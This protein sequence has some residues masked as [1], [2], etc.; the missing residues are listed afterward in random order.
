MMRYDR[1]KTMLPTW[2]DVGP[3]APPAAHEARRRAS[4]L[5]MA[6]MAVTAIAGIIGLAALARTVTRPQLEPL[7]GVSI[8]WECACIWL[9]PALYDLA[10]RSGESG[11]LRSHDALVRLAEQPG[12]KDSWY[13]ITERGIK[14][15]G[16]A[17]V[18]S[19]IRRPFEMMADLTTEFP[20][21]LATAA[22]K[23]P[24]STEVDY[25]R[26]EVGVV[27][28][29]LLSLNPREAFYELQM[30]GSIPRK[31]KGL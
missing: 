21:V 15:D 4:R 22:G 2:T 26:A 3:F 20:D 27:P 12:L 16:S 5:E 9:H 1:L 10:R 11:E 13:V 8:R 6:A 25:S 28:D 30:L 7:A 24:R 23:P 14:S 17:A 31:E 19:F 18:I 29:R